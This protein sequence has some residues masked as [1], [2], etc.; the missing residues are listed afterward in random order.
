MRMFAA[1]FEHTTT[2]M[3]RGTGM[4]KEVRV[5]NRIVIIS[6]EGIKFEADQRHADVVVKQLRLE[7]ANVVTTPWDDGIAEK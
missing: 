4:E 6:N 1:Q 7:D 3:G 5:L 2:T